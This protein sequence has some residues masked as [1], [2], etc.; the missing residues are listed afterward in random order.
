MPAHPESLT[1]LEDLLAK[2]RAAGAEAADAVLFESTA[3]SH[4]QRL[5]ALERLE[6]EESRDLGLRVLI[7][8]RQAFVSSTDMKPAALDE[9]VERALAM[10]RTVPEDKYC[11]LAEPGELAT[12]IPE[13]DL[14]DPAEPAPEALIE[15][16]RAC[17][18]AA[19][20][21]EG[22]TN[23]EGAEAGWSRS[24]IALAASNGFR[25]GY[26]GSHHSVGVSVLAG[27]GLGM[28]TDYDFS[29]S[30]YGA[31]LEDPEAVGRRAGERAVRRLGSRKAKTGRVPVVY[32][33]RV[34]NGLLRHLA[35]AI[36]GPAIARG[37]S[38]LKD[39]LG[40]P[41]F[42]EGITVIDEPHRPRGL[43]SKP[44]DAEGLAN[45]KREVIA[46]GVLTTWILSLSSARQ[47]GLSSTGHA[48]RGT[49]GPPGP[50][51]TNLYMNPGTRSPAELIAEIDQGFYVTTM[52]GM[53]VN[54]VTGDYSRGAAGFWIE[55]GE[56]AY[57]V[58]EVTVAGNLKEMFRRLTPANDLAFRYGTDAP[59]IRIEGMTVAGS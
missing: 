37:T 5:G 12:S 9:L 49:S 15:R 51:T 14:C 19:L 4:A 21:I 57:P 16:A 7:G 53:G 58:S 29:T 8:R 35:G 32:D 43:R 1:L 33:P 50:A 44:F 36:S 40:E 13:I 48:A 30:V 22:V 31:D 52:M 2:A 38:F 25:G 23:S 42:A 56:L 17:E 24:R 59:T 27:E 6:R 10:A 46:D 54:A 39:R 55:K 47:L 28:E 45:K 26:E 20:A 11:G 18:E 34:A 41:V 3:L